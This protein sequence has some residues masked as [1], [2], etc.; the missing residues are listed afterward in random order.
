[1]MLWI[2]DLLVVTL[3]VYCDNILYGTF[4]IFFHTSLLKLKDYR[5]NKNRER[6]NP[7]LSINDGV[8]INT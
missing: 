2:N 5:C 1:M 6:N 8:Y 3:V 7:L 4:G